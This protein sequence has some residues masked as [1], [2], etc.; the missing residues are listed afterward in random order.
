MVVLFFAVGVVLFVI[1]AVIRDLFEYRIV[2]AID[3]QCEAEGEC[4]INLSSVT[5]FDWD[6]VAI[7]T[8]NGDWVKMGKVLQIPN[9][10]LDVS[11]GIVYYSNGEV[12]KMQTQGYDYDNPPMLSYG[13]ERSS[14]DDPYYRIHTVDDADL[15]AIKISRESGGYRY[16]LCG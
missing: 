8:A 4:T 16:I 15:R 3:N 9:V 10:N 13:I 6:T 7:F 14:L 11:E 2:R 12:V 5:D 1:Y